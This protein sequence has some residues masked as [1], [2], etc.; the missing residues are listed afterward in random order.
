LPQPSKQ[1]ESISVTKYLLTSAALLLAGFGLWRVGRLTERTA[2][3]HERLLLM[4]YDIPPR[5]D[6]SFEGDRLTRG[7]MRLLEPG[8]ASQQLEQRAIADY[9]SGRY[10]AVPP[11]ATSS[12]GADNPSAASRLL[13]V[14]AAYRAAA[15][16]DNSPSAVQRMEGLLTQYADVLRQSSW[17]FDAAYNYEFVA[18]HRDALIRARAARPG[19]RGR[20]A[21][22]PVAPPLHTIHGRPGSVPPGVDMRDFKIVVPQRSDERRVQPEAGK[23]GP[24]A[25]RG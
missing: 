8:S 19:Q 15:I 16:D 20:E 1:R 14:N 18:R 25:R 11:A 6:Q 4:R 5:D 24:K 10:D 3:V 21:A 17:L 13:A 9:W 2:E 12:S 22:D 23:G 7:L